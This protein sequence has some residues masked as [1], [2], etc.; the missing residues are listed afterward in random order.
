MYKVKKAPGGRNAESMFDDSSLLL[1]GLLFYF[2]LK[3]SFKANDL[4]R[5]LHLS[6]LQE[7]CDYITSFL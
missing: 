5:K 3:N 1:S 6:D 2:T 4:Q 7:N